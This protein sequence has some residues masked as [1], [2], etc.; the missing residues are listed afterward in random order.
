MDQEELIEG[1]LSAN[2]ACGGINDRIKAL[3]RWVL[4]ATNHLHGAG[5]GDPVADSTWVQVRE[6]IRALEAAEMSVEVASKLLTQA[7]YN[8]EQ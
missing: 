2:V 5:E 6:A 7:G 8:E 4:A 1:L 3:R